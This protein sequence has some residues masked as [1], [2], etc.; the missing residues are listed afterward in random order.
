MSHTTWGADRETMLKLYKATVLPILEYGSQIYTSASKSILKLLD[1]VHHLGLRLAT[2]AFRS[3]PTSSLIVDSGDM[4][5]H[6]RFEITTICRALKLKEGLSPV[7]K[8]FLEKDLFFHSKIRNP[9]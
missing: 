3:S 1:P 4:P 7:K 8:K 9:V 2:G 6:Y 5:L